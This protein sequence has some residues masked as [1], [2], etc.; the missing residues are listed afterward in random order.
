M[1]QINGSNIL[2]TRGD[3]AR[4]SIT[5]DNLA[6][7]KAYELAADDVLIFAVKKYAIDSFPVLL[8]KECTGSSD[9]YIE[10]EDTKKIPAGAYKYDVELHH[11]DDV[12]TVINAAD[13][14]LMSEVAV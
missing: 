6:T 14:Q 2:L 13:F 8:K 1:F 7:G 12:Y 5:I 10:P 4:F 11:A 3:S 9:F